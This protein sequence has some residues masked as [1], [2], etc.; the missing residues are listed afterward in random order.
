MMVPP[1]ALKYIVLSQELIKMHFLNAN[2]VTD[3][4][5]VDKIADFPATMTA[6]KYTSPM[7]CV[8]CLYRMSPG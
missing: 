6:N 3:S 4:P 8:G 2:L 7:M 5:Y 1:D